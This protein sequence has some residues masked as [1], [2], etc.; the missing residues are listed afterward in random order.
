[1]ATP[2]SEPG[3]P[4]ERWGGFI[5]VDPGDPPEYTIT[6]R[7][8]GPIPGEEGI[9]SE[10][11]GTRVVATPNDL[12]GVVEPEDLVEPAFVPAGYALTGAYVVV[13]ESG[14][15]VDYHLSYHRI[16]GSGASQDPDVFAPDL[17]VAWTLRA[18]RPLPVE[19]VTKDVERGRIGHPGEKLEVRG[20][21]AVY[22]RWDNPEGL[23]P[24]LVI[25]SNLAWFDESGRLWTVQANEPLEVL[26][27]VA[28]SLTPVA[29]TIGQ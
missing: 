17:L 2:T 3:I 9:P 7:P 6:P 29:S 14:K 27:R 18:P 5:F 20:F 8:S 10:F 26:Y 13:L 16:E 19:L 22:K 25:R 12:A 1:M 23:H 4:G 15:V 28:D 11:P 24:S 21:P